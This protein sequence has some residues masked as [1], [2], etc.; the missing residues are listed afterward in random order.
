MVRSRWPERPCAAGADWLAVALPEEA[1]ALRAAGVDAPILLLSEPPRGTAA[2]VVGLG[3]RPTLYTAAG[4]DAFAFAPGHPVH[5][6]VDTGMNRVG[7]TTD[8][9]VGLAERVVAAGLRLEGVWTHCPV[10]D[11][12]DNPFTAAQIDRFDAGAR[13][14]A[15]RGRRPRDDPHGQLGGDASPI[16]P[17]TPTSCGSASP[18][19]AWRP[20]PRSR[21]PRRSVR[22]MTLALGGRLREAGACR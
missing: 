1:A 18:S 14:P 8:A 15:G 12:P 16:R 17:P 10:A 5:L 4:I 7:A 3:V 2:E 6:N 20:R 13:G 11:E 22:R 19:T 21:T 9:V